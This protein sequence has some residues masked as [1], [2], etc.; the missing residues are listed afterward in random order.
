MS[1]DII[2]LLIIFELTYLPKRIVREPSPV[3]L[4]A[5]HLTLNK[6]FDMDELFNYLISDEVTSVCVSDPPNV[7]SCLHDMI[8]Q[9][10]AKTF[11]R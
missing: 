5:L 10:N 4:G 6:T 3:V 11:L 9:Y 2:P 7:F 8:G 1:F